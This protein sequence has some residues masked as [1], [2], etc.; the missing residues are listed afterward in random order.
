MIEGDAGDEGA[1]IRDLG[2]PPQRA[3]GVEIIRKDEPV[4]GGQKQSGSA[5]PLRQA[6]LQLTGVVII[7]S[8]IHACSWRTAFCRRRSLGRYVSRGRGRARS[9]QVR[10]PASRD[11]SSRPRRLMLRDQE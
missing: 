4:R 2:S 10:R 9:P 8:R 5:A 6:A 3:G 7:S 11:G 1:L